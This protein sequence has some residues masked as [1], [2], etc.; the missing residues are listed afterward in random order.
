MTE[1]PLLIPAQAPAFTWPSAA[2]LEVLLAS[3]LFAP[4]LRNAIEAAVLTGTTL[5]PPTPEIQQELTA[6]WF[7]PD[8]GSWEAWCAMHHLHPQIL[9]P[10][11]MRRHA[12]Q[13]WKEQHFEARARDQFLEQ[14]PRLDRLWF[15]IL[16]TADPGVAQ[17][18]YF[19]L[20]DGDALFDE[21]ALRSEAVDRGQATRF[22]P[23][24]MQD[25]QSPLDRLLA[26]A[27]PG[28]VQPP[29]T[30]PS[31]RTVVLRL[32]QRQPACWDEGT[33]QLL[34][35]GLHRQ[36]LS[37]VMDHLRQ[38]KPQPGTVCPIPLP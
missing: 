5:P 26:R 31:G 20:L 17:E 22:G 6:Q 16:Q 11:L 25:V 30:L 37:Q 38:L 14:G 32:D 13:S 3:E 27:A 2:V 29:L 10:A 23:V 1:S 24:R 33:R 36:W 34:L 15:S 4:W 9:D 7:Q 19:K 8:E 35:D 28:E 21:L 18:W 12:L